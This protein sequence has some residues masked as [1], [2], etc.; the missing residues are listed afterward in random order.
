MYFITNRNLVSKDKYFNTIKKASYYG[1]NNII[2]REKDLNDKEYEELYYEVKK[3]VMP[4]TNIII[5][6]KINVLNKVKANTIHL[7]YKDYMSFENIEN[8]RVGVSVHSVKEGIDAA[9]KGATYLLAS[10]IFET[11]CKEGLEP[12]GLNFIKELRDKVSCEIVAL[13]G[14]NE[15]NYK[16]TLLVGVNDFA[17]MSLLFNSLNLKD[18]INNLT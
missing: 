16:E 15:K 17:V 4:S 3:I 1:V 13:G 18:T 5:H 6:S 14:I 11:K 9:G 12:K 8:I 7:T 2:L 10:H